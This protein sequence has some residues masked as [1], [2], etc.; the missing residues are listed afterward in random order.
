MA[1]RKPPPPVAPA[2][3]VDTLAVTDGR[4]LLAPK[5]VPLKGFSKP[6]PFSF[7]S[8]LESGQLDAVF[9]IPTG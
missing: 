8:K 6:F 3:H 4:L 2:W 9:D 5:G 7:T 1:R